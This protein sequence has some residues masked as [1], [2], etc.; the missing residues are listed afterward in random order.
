MEEGESNDYSPLRNDEEEEDEEN[1][2][3]LEAMLYSQI[4]YDHS[5]VKERDFTIND[6]FGDAPDVEKALCESPS[7]V[8]S[9][10]E[11][12]R[13]GSG[14]Q[15]G[16]DIDSEEDSELEEDLSRKRKGDFPAYPGKSNKFNSKKRPDW[17]LTKALAEEAEK[18]NQVFL[19]KDRGITKGCGEKFSIQSVYISHIKIRKLNQGMCPDLLTKDSSVKPQLSD[20]KYESAKGSAKPKLVENPFFDSDASSDSEEEDDGIILLPKDSPKSKETEVIEIDCDSSNSAVLITDTDTEDD[21]VDE[22]NDIPNDDSIQIVEEV[23]NIKR[24]NNVTEI[25]KSLSKKRRTEQYKA[26]FGSDFED[27][28]ETDAASSS[29]EDGDQ[30]AA[31]QTSSI[32]LNLTSSSHNTG[33]RKGIERIVGCPLSRL[34]SKSVPDIPSHWTK[35]MDKFYNRV[36]EDVLDMDLD[37]VFKKLPRSSNWSIDRADLYGGGEGEVF[38]DPGDSKLFFP[39]QVPK[40]HGTS[41]IKDAATVIKLVT[42]PA[43]LGAHHQILYQNIG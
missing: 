10:Y 3:E 22:E 13:P 18:E 11:Q 9:G 7:N 15:D 28:F 19:C 42:L 6:T 41:Q 8:D 23:Q 40:D 30:G 25:N 32:T 27:N 37:D 34:R 43:R 2:E 24:K 36:N 39:F 33:G 38:M 1:L 20:S 14:I 31:S 17:S 29:D 35:E 5:E 12:S 21:D 26:D 4:Y 16:E